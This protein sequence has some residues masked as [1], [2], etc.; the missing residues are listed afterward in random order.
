MLE[1][2]TFRKNRGVP[3]EAECCKDATRG[4]KVASSFHSLNPDEIDKSV[5]SY[6]IK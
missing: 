2:E 4:Q 3:S 5:G 1:S 6:S